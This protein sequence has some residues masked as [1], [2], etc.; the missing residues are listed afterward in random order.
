MNQPDYNSKEYWANINRIKNQVEWGAAS[1]QERNI[2]KM[3][4]KRV[5]K[6]KNKK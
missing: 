4:N 6:L 5:K 1:Y 2:L 3:H